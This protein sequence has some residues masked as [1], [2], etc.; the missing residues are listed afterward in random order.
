MYT[1]VA[2]VQAYLHVN[3][4]FRVAEY[5]VL[6]AIRVLNASCCDADRM[7]RQY[8]LHAYSLVT[9]DEGSIAPTD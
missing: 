4:Y 8:L 9:N 6:E 7:V 3:G 5:P 1:S 2:F